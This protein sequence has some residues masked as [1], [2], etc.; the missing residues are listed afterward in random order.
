ML[1]ALLAQAALAQNP[2]AVT[3]PKALPFS[4]LYAS[5]YPLEARRRGWE[6]TVVADLTI[7]V[8][9]AVDKCDLVK[10][11]GYKLLDDTTC[12]ILVRRARFHPAHD[13]DGNAVVDKVRSPEISWKATH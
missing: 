12:R 10:S 1:F 4:V 9:G 3:H 5:D 7:S 6:G 11:S 13:K 8:S 2:L